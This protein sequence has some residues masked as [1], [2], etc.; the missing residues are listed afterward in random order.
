M[1][2]VQVLLSSYNGEKYIE[3]QLDSIFWQKGVEVSCLIRDDGSSDN[4][5]DIIKKYQAKQNGLKLV[6]G[7]NIG[8]RKSFFELL[9]LANDADY[10]AFSDQDDEWF[11]N[12]LESAVRLLEQK[13]S[14]KPL[15]FHSARIRKEADR[16]IEQQMLQQPLNF[17]NALVQEYCQ[18]C[19]IVINRAAR[20]LLCKYYPSGKLGYDFWVGLICYCF[21]EICYSSKPLFYHINHIDNTTKTGNRIQCISARFK[22]AIKGGVTYNNPCYELLSGYESNLTKEQY[23]I[24]NEICNY[25]KN[26]KTKIKLLL[27]KEF[28]RNTIIGT[29]FLKICVLLNKY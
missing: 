5:I 2:K 27:D 28:I 17:K 11:D 16:E 7:N 15:L 22:N 26:W 6:K 23:K 21:G 24:V 29:A 8:W 13:E 3:H 9:L 14:N 10:Y 4:T 18:G 25:K 20:D 1:K 19:S 12:K